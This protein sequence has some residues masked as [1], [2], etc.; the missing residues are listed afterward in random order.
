MDSSFAGVSHILKKTLS[1]LAKKQPLKAETSDASV[2]GRVLGA[3][4]KD[5][6]F[7]QDY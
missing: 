1:A 6:V 7:L 5:C 4:C 2:A 3:L